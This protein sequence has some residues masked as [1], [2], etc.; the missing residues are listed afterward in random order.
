MRKKVIKMEPE[1]AKAQEILDHINSS[2]EEI[3]LYEMRELTRMDIQNARERNIQEGME[4]GD[5]KGIKKGIN[6]E[7]IEVALISIK[8]KI[9]IKTISKITGLPV[10]K[11]ENLKKEQEKN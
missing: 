6:E 5:E 1:L 11:I 8:E 10:K 3:E 7:K 9:P 4:I 2:P